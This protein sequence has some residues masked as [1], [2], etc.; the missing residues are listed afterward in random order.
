MK[1]LESVLNRSFV[2]GIHTHTVIYVKDIHSFCSVTVTERKLNQN[3][4]QTSEK[5]GSI[6]Y[7]TREDGE[8]FYLGKDKEK[9]LF[10][11]KNRCI[12]N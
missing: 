6:S 10:A 9:A 12:V 8:L 1:N 2:R 11:A 4:H 7:E 5:K 3:F